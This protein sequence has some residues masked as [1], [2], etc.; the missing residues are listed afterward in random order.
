MAPAQNAKDRAKRI[1]IYARWLYPLAFLLFN[2]VYWGYYLNLNP[3][4]MRS[5][6]AS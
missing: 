4:S 2:V 6:P 3:E 1:D 5:R